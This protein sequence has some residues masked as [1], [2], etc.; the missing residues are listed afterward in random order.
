MKAREIEQPWGYYAPTSMSLVSTWIRSRIKSKRVKKYLLRWSLIPGVYDISWSGLNLRCHAEDNHTEN[1]LISKAKRKPELDRLLDE[2]KQGEVFIDI[3][4]NCGIFSLLAAKTVGPLGRAIAIEPNPAMVRRLRFN[5]DANGLTNV[6]VAE[7]AL[8]ESDGEAVLY[9]TPR[10]YGLSTLLAREKCLKITVRVKTLASVCR[11]NEIE[12]IGAIKIDIEGYED[13]VMLPFLRTAP[14]ALWPRAILTET[15]C[16]HR[17]REDCV[18][19]FQ[20][21]GYSVKWQGKR[22]VLL[23]LEQ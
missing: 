15:A 21:A 20:D 14:K 3:G 22:D 17:W 9:L 6:T 2:L 19:H 4:A 12:R 10:Q 13:R 7:A 1:V 16:S 5:I 8:G 18:R 23:V 11:E